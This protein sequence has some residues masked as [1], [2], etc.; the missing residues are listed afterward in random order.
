MRISADNGPMRR[1]LTTLWGRGSQLNALRMGASALALVLAL[2]FA[3]LG[4]SS[5]VDES[6]RLMRDGLHPRAATGKIVLIEVDA[7]SLTRLSTW[8]WP[9]RLHAK[10]L[11][12]LREAGTSKV[13]FDIDFSASTSPQDDRLFGE[14][15]ARFGGSVILPTFRQ[16]ASSTSQDWVENLP[17]APLRDNAFLGSVNVQPDRDGQL[18]KLSF[19]TITDGTP[20]PAIAALLADSRGRMGESFT[21][22]GAIDLASVPRIS[23]ADVLTGAVS[24]EKLR[25]KSVLIGATAIEMGDRYSVPGLGVQPGA[26]IQVLGAETLAQGT[27]NPNFGS[28]PALLVAILGA[29]GL[30]RRRTAGLGR[31]GLAAAIMG[32]PFGL[33]VAGVASLDVAPALAFLGLEAAL[34]AA[35]ANVQSLRT[36]RLVD[37]ETGLP[38]LRALEQNCRDIP[39]LTIVALHIKQFSELNAVLEV[40]DRKLLV[41]KIADRLQLSF[42]G[43]PVYAVEAGTLAVPV[44]DAELDGLIDTVEGLCG[45][46]RSAIDIGSRSVL[47]LPAF[48]ISR[49]VGAGANQLVAEAAL[50]ARQAV[51]ANQR[52]LLHN[53]QV[54]NDADRS[55]ILLSGVDQAL[56]NGEIHV[57]FQPKWLVKESRIGGAEALVRWK[58]PQFGPV[59][60]DLFIPLLEDNGHIEELTLFVVDQCLANLNGWR[61][62]HP[63]IN[64]AVNISAALLDNAAFVDQLAARITAQAGMAAALTLEVTESATIASAAPAIAALE[65]LRGLGVRISIDDYGTGQSTLTYLKSFPADE[66]KIDKSFVT[67]MASNHSD[68]ILVRSTIELAHELG[69]KVVAE[70][71]EDGQCLEMLTRFG[72]DVAQGWHIGKPDTAALLQARLEGTQSAASRAA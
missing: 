58:H 10:L 49:G 64:L 24:P 68:Q 34:L 18:R 43:L 1:A 38:N 26:L 48:G 69:F 72:C 25:G 70:G 37:A 39:A 30:T 40:A 3:F 55:L 41:G 65:R 16:P 2:A 28:W 5:A 4:A 13:A 67:G 57:L 51:S 71:V 6:L 8:P 50:A 56:T 19:G 46:L 52:W 9:R 61:A 11:D 45:L 14:A 32:L 22:D 7:K 31:A 36:A 42:P 12:Q 66:I 63:D 20:R 33:E 47:V 17:V 29:F 62:S 60:P 35:V 59:S 44:A 23:Y 53:D 15:L 21:I 27:T 54:A